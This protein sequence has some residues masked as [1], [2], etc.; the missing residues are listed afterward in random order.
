MNEFKQ[1]HKEYTSQVKNLEDPEP[2]QDRLDKLQDE[3]ETLDHQIDET[4]A[5][6][7]NIVWTK[8]YFLFFICFYLLH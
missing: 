6:I 1:V 7:Q 8:A 5:K 2:L 4:F 3:D